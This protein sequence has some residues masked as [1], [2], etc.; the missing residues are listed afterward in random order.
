[1]PECRTFLLL[2][3]IYTTTNLVVVAIDIPINNIHNY[4]RNIYVRYK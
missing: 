1:M 3:N 4:L 2:E